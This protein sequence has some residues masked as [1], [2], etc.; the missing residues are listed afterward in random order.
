MNR[1][2]NCVR[3]CLFLPVDISARACEVPPPLSWPSWH[4]STHTSLYATPNYLCCIQTFNLHTPDATHINHRPYSMSVDGGN[5]GQY[6]CK[7]KTCPGSD[8]ILFSHARCAQTTQT[9]IYSAW[10]RLSL[11]SFCLILCFIHP[12]G[13]A[14]PFCPLFAWVELDSLSL[15]SIL[16]VYLSLIAACFMGHLWN[17]TCVCALFHLCVCV[18]IFVRSR[19]GYPILLCVIMGGVFRWQK[20]RGMGRLERAERGSPGWAAANE[21][22][23]D[24][25]EFACSRQLIRQTAEPRPLQQHLFLLWVCQLPLRPSFLPLLSRICIPGHSRYFS[26]FDCWGRDIQRFIKRPPEVLSV[27]L[28]YFKMCLFWISAWVLCKA[29]HRV[30]ILSISSS[31][32]WWCL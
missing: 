19:V 22:S 23:P 3:V 6:L 30:C 15:S 27:Y 5:V 1:L 24:G 28:S 8:L 16:S 10:R 11:A 29:Q 7:N 2:Y 32:L 21:R 26:V 20:G 25:H 18:Y 13:C 31:E 12:T 9:D 17:C 14:P 4:V